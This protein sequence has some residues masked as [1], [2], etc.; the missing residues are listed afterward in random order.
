[1]RPDD[2]VQ[3]FADKY[4]ENI[5]DAFRTLYTEEQ[6]SDVTIHCKEGSVKAHKLIL[7]ASSPY[8]CKV[9]RENRNEYPIIILH[10]ITL[11][12]LENLMDLLY[13]GIVDVPSNNLETITSL[14]REFEIKGVVVGERESDNVRLE[15]NQNSQTVSPESA[16]NRDTRFKGQKRVAVDFVYEEDRPQ[17]RPTSTSSLQSNDIRLPKKSGQGDLPTSAPIIVKREV[18]SPMSYS[19]SSLHS[20]RD[21]LTISEPKPVFEHVSPKLN[22]WA[23]KQRKFKCNL[24]PSSFKRSSHLTR[25][26]LVHTGERPYSCNQCDK[27]FSRH[28]KLKHH[29]RKAHEFIPDSMYERIDAGEINE[30]SDTESSNRHYSSPLQNGNILNEPSTSNTEFSRASS[31]NN[32]ERT[33]SPLFTISH[34]TSIL[35]DSFVIPPKKGRGRPRKYPPANLPLHNKVQEPFQSDGTTENKIIQTWLSQG[36]SRHEKNIMGQRKHRRREVDFLSKENM[37]YTGRLRAR[38]KSLENNLGAVQSTF[39]TEKK[40]AN[41]YDSVNVAAASE[42]NVSRNLSPIVFCDVNQMS[43]ATSTSKKRPSKKQQ[44]MGSR[45]STRIKIVE[46]RSKK[47]N[48]IKNKDS[49]SGNYSAVSITKS[50]KQKHTTAA[51][52]ATKAIKRP[53]GRPRKIPQSTSLNSELEKKCAYEVKLIERKNIILKSRKSFSEINGRKENSHLHVIQVNKI[54][55]LMI[56]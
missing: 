22:A 54:Q 23:R 30:D 42:T 28:D 46:Q 13:R 18:S 19:D 43:L 55:N 10:G 24:C 41:F 44:K 8:F 17:S 6:L 14:V 36:E 27:A 9:F 1:M 38:S 37:P 5:S 33:N 15:L 7:A 3:V 49:T 39:T 52:Q 29:V 35:E 20:L 56:Q 25:H 34:I 48:S 11:T 16:H 21:N 26:Q 51:I 12:Q 40:T 45:K 4:L 47:T 50:M 53:I 31:P 32:Y 2:L